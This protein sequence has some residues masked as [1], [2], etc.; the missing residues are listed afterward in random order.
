MSREYIQK[1]V[2]LVLSDL[3]WDV[4]FREPMGQI[5]V[6][7]RRIAIAND[8]VVRARSESPSFRLKADV[9]P[10]GETWFEDIVEKSGNEWG[11]QLAKSGSRNTVTW[12]DERWEAGW[13]LVRLADAFQDLIAEEVSDPIPL[14]PVHGHNHPMLPKQLLSEG[15][16]LCPKGETFSK[17]K[18]GHIQGR[19]M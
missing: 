18:I 14:C 4:L 8:I 13:I 2:T 12:V 7:Q 11:I 17:V 9:L 10:P 16:W 6:E 5:F 19:A 15:F 1:L 3:Q